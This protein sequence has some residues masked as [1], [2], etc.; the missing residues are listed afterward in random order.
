MLR[1]YLVLQCSH[2]PQCR[3]AICV[4]MPVSYTSGQPS[5]PRRH[6]TCWSLSLAR[7]AVPWSKAQHSPVYRVGMHS[8]W[9]RDTHLYPPRNNLSVYLAKTDYNNLRAAHCGVRGQLQKTT[10]FRPPTP[11]PINA[12]TPAHIHRESDGFR[13]DQ[14]DIASTEVQTMH[15]TRIVLPVASTIARAEI[16]LGCW[17]D[18]P[19]LNRTHLVLFRWEGSR[20]YDRTPTKN[21]SA[22][23][24]FPATVIIPSTWPDWSKF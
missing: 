12:P 4:W 8:A 21:A 19:F 1:S 10:H 17:R 23:E 22:L 24:N 3:L 14:N 7:R 15:S 16:C 5:Y 9:N 11:A 2:P 6:P 18:L 20:Q 13:D